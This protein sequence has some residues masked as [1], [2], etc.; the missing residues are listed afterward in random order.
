M[1]SLILLFTDI[2]KVFK[3]IIPLLHAS[4][5]FA[6]KILIVFCFLLP[7]T[8]SITEKKCNA[9]QV[10][11]STA[12]TDSIKRKSLEWLSCLQVNKN[13]SLFFAFLTTIWE[14]LADESQ[15]PSA[16]I[17]DKNTALLLQLLCKVV[18]K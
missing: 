6:H 11:T 7:M 5:Q 17:R 14:D 15:V 9:S 4:Y 2:I 8:F 10:L 3:K 18:Q 1:K 12:V 13:S 16:K